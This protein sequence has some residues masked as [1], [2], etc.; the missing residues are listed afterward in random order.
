MT[1]TSTIIKPVT[2]LVNGH[3]GP[4]MKQKQILLEHTLGNSVTGLV[5]AISFIGKEVVYLLVLLLFS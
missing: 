1:L 4:E 2:Q 3:F 5:E